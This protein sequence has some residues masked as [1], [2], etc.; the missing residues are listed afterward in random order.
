[1]SSLCLS[2]QQ[3]ERGGDNS[4]VTS[5][6]PCNLLWFNLKIAVHDQVVACVTRVQDFR[7]HKWNGCCAWYCRAGA[8]A[9]FCPCPAA[10]RETLA[11]WRVTG[12]A[13]WHCPRA[14]VGSGGRRARGGSGCSA[15]ERSRHRLRSQLS[16]LCHVWS[17]SPGNACPGTSRRNSPHKEVTAAEQSPCSGWFSFS[18]SLGTYIHPFLL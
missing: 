15:A 1:M 3:K 12:P 7:S 17:S 11:R 6:F 16:S 18:H 5:F 8:S 13:W 10:P 4:L 2:G 14:P 9:R